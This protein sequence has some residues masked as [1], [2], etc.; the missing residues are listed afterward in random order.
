MLKKLLVVLTTAALMVGL[1]GVPAHAVLVST[2]PIKITEQELD[3]GADPWMI[4][5]PLNRA[6]LGWDNTNGLRSAILSGT[7]YINNASGTCARMRLES[8]DANHNLVNSRNDGTFCAPN[9]ALHSRIV[10]F[11][12]PASAS[13]THAH[14]V[15][16]VQNSNGTYSD[17]GTDYADY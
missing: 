6:V 4:G 8:Y 16:Q 13:I 1:S 15:L 14:A 10:Y 12:A 3:F 11:A 5:A 9:G 17:A 7:L 2:D